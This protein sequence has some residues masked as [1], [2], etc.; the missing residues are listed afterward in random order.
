MIKRVLLSSAALAALTTAGFAA[1]LPGRAA[2][3]APYY[4]PAPV[5]TW[6]GFYIGVNAGG[7][8]NS[9]NSNSSTSFNG[10][11]PALAGVTTT[12]VPVPTAVS[13]VNNS[14]SNGN[15]NRGQFLGGGQIGYNYQFGQFVAGL[16]ADIQGIARSN[17]NNNGFSN[18]DS[19]FAATACAILHINGT[20]S[21]SIQNSNYFGTVRGRIGYAM[22]RFM[23][24]ATGGFAYSGRGN[25]NNNN[26]GFG[27][28]NNGSYINYINNTAGGAPST[29]YFNVTN[30]VAAINNSNNNYGYTVGGGVEY[31]FT[32]NLSLKAE[33]LYVNTNRHNNNSTVLNPNGVYANTINASTF[34]VA[35]AT[36]G[37]V[38]GNSSRSGGLN[39][40]RLGLNYRF[41]GFSQAPAVVAK[42]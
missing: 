3:P 34:T 16:E 35:G 15:N 24:F 8:F 2:A 18:N 21:S 10:G 28:F 14:S 27:N 36:A 6:T 32:N 19:C 26:G 22:D 40:V 9:N 20:N 13:I 12:V 37:T 17:N 7:G 42:Y 29:T 39:V 33:Y 23:I 30:P 11:F 38:G 25:N 1:D 5:F 31:A 4:A 41:G